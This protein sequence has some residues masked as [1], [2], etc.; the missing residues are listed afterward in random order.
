M[1]PQLLLLSTLSA[2]SSA[3]QPSPPPPLPTPSQPPIS[4]TQNATAPSGPPLPKLK[5][6]TT[7]DDGYTFGNLV[8]HN[9]CS[10]TFHL[11]SV[12]AHYLGGSRLP[13][14]PS[15]SPLPSERTLS[16]TI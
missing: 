14:S 12:G 1:F 5:N 13:L 9:W 6:L 8:I 2:L 3:T 7:P 15:S 4:P 10:E 11:R 16:A